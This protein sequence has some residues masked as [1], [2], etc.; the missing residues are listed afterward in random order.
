VTSATPPARQRV[1]VTGAAG[2]IGGRL[3]ERLVMDGMEVHGVSR[4]ARSG[5]GVHW[6][7]ADLSCEAETRRV[8]DT[9][10]PEVIFHLAGRPSAS[11]G[12]DL[13]LPTLQQNL[14]A[15]VNVMVAAAEVGA[16][17]L[18]LAGSLEEGDALESDSGSSSPYALSKQ[19]ASAYARMLQSLYGLP[20]VIARIFMVY[21]P[22]QNESEKLIP[23]LITSL[24]RGE[25]PRLGSG[26][27]PV[28]WVF[29]DDVVD[30]LIAIGHAPGLVGETIDVGSG[31]LVTIRALVE[32]VL[33]ILGTDTDPTF[34]ELPERKR[35]TVRTANTTRTR[36]ATGWRAQVPLEDGLRTTIQW[37]RDQGA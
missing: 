33:A 13:V 30:A 31:E 37:Y 18:V 23:Y 6:L 32:R 34:G 1:L 19:A 7:Q 2:F 4:Q 26:E 16:G 11:R 22:G 9:V 21:G 5:G 17:R 36:E 10:G 3:C 24:L 14:V 35:E 25:S 20:V 8:F 12:L 29:V 27:R 15:A 28:D